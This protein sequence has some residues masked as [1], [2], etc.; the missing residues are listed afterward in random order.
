[1]I[2][3]TGIKTVTKFILKD[4]EIQNYFTQWAFNNLNARNYYQ[5]SKAE[6]YS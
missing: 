5:I 4:F 2:N 3:F 1:M 6:S